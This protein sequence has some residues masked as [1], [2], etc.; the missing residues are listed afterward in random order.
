MPS[1]PQIILSIVP[2]ITEQYQRKT[3]PIIDLLHTTRLLI[4]SQDMS[5]IGFSR[6]HTGL[7]YL[8]P[9]TCEGL[10]REGIEVWWG[11]PIILLDGFCSLL[12]GQRWKP[13]MFHMASILSVGRT[14]SLLD[15]AKVSGVDACLT[16][17]LSSHCPCNNF[18]KAAMGHSAPSSD[19][20][21]GDSWTD[22]DNAQRVRLFQQSPTRAL[23]AVVLLVSAIVSQGTGK[24]GPTSS[25]SQHWLSV[26]EVWGE[27][28]HEEPFQPVI[29]PFSLWYQACSEVHTQVL[30][31]STV[32]PYWGKPGWQTIGAR[33]EPTNLAPRR[34]NFD[35]TEFHH[36]F[37]T[38]ATSDEGFCWVIY[39]WYNKIT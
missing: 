26:L 13:A 2:D 30:L 23:V 19:L 32:G 5:E 18:R 9:R 33:M 4:P 34:R 1:C 10:H 25:L 28:A 29:H 7:S 37:V 12:L 14:Q 27:S 8:R 3:A 35:F 6:I 24:R 38:S 31:T 20:G 39:H 15:D 11:D 21:Q 22:I 16:P 36:R 17:Y